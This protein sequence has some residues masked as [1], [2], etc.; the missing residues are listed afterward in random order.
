M[1]PDRIREIRQRA[2]MSQ[3]EFAQTFNVS[4][5]TVWRWEKGRRTPTE[6]HEAALDQFEKR[7]DQAERQDQV[8]EFVK[9]IVGGAAF[10]GVGWLLGKLFSEGDSTELPNLEDSDS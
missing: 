10:F 1:S 8:R 4:L 5:Q 6:W 7:L 2:G 3:E 9:G